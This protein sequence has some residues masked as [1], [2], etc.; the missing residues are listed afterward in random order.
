MI[1]QP[2]YCFLINTSSNASKAGTF[3]SEHEALLKRK[4]PESELVFIE[5]EDSIAEIAALKSKQHTHIIACGGDGTVN[6]VVNGIIGRK[7]TLGVIPLGSGNDFAK[8]LG[9]SKN[10]K[11]NLS[12]LETGKTKAIDVVKNEWGYFVN[13][14]GIGLDGLTN[15]HASNSPF[16]RGLLRYFWGG[17]KAL[18]QAKPFDVSVSIPELSGQ[19]SYRSWMITV[20]NGKI[21]GGRYKISPTSRNDDGKLE[22]LIVKDIKR[23]RLVYEFLK[24]SAGLSFN[25]NIVDVFVTK[26]GCKTVCNRVVKSHADGEQVY[27][28]KVNN[29]SLLPGAINVIIND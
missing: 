26:K 15:F 12:I 27:T 21:E 23:L 4:F 19:I 17:L 8:S 29:F 18:F 28:H 10:F 3:V 7:V 14:F 25:K 20:T 22:I 1:E 2:S 24:L 6:Q 9:L 13:T 11:S 16:K 5:R